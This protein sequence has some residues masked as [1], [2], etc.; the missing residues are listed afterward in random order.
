MPEETPLQTKQEL[1]VLTCPHCR[2]AL[3]IDDSIILCPECNSRASIQAGINNF[4]VSGKF[5]A[6][7]S[8]PPLND[9]NRIA[10]TQ[11]WQTAAEKIASNSPNP[12]HLLEYITSEARADFRFLLPVTQE[13]I[14]LDVCGGWGNITAAFARTCK[15]VFSLDS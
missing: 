15:H 7:Q 1:P 6:A 2:I 14:V 10:S 4:L 11:G 13:D 9:F 3:H 8:D 12:V 5:S